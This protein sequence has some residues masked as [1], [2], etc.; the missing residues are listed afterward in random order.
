[1]IRTNAGKDSS[2]AGKSCSTGDALYSGEY[3]LYY[4]FIFI[5]DVTPSFFDEC[6]VM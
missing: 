5:L 2:A 1:M 3:I 6:T 4:G